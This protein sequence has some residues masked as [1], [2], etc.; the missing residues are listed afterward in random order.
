MSGKFYSEDAEVHVG[1]IV[2]PLRGRWRPITGQAKAEDFKNA[3]LEPALWKSTAS[4]NDDNEAKMQ[5]T[6]KMVYSSDRLKESDVGEEAETRS[7]VSA[8]REAPKKSVLVSPCPTTCSCG[9]ASSVLT[10]NSPPPE[11]NRIE[12]PADLADK[13]QDAWASRAK[14][15][16]IK[17]SQVWTAKSKSL[18]DDSGKASQSSSLKTPNMKETPKK[19]DSSEEIRVTS[20]PLP[21][22]K[23][24]LPKKSKEKLERKGAKAG[25]RPGSR[26]GSRASSREKAKDEPKNREKGKEEP[27]TKVKANVEKAPPKEEKIRVK[28][29]LQDSNYISDVPP[30]GRSSR[31]GSPKRKGTEIAEIRGIDIP[32]ER[33]RPIRANLTTTSRSRLKTVTY[34]EEPF[35][36]EFKSWILLIIFLSMILLYRSTLLS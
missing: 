25:S 20:S 30:S 21:R 6:S 33:T 32:K 35:L 4:D 22:P 24:T 2:R 29:D 17:K 10:V 23:I 19:Q 36:S 7:D 28:F 9:A 8:P 14:Q 11:M 31:P 5:F 15:T 1:V 34:K 27:K 18:K 26:V 12:L 3:T 13:N 16:E